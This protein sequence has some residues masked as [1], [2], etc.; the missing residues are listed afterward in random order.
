MTEKEKRTMRVI[1][2]TLNGEINRMCNT[3]ELLEFVSMS[4][5]AKE[6]LDRLA[7]LIYE[8]RFKDV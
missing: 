4:V 7:N 5:Y 8:A 6:N 2:V 1:I 3:N